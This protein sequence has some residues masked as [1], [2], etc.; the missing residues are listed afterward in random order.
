VS[1]GAVPSYVAI[2]LDQPAM[3]PEWKSWLTYALALRGV[4]LGTDGTIMEGDTLIG[5]F[6]FLEPDE[7][8]A[9]L[10][11]ANVEVRARECPWA[12]P[13]RGALGWESAGSV[14]ELLRSFL[15]LLIRLARG[16]LVRTEDGAHYE[17]LRRMAFSL[18]NLTGKFG[19]EDGEALL[20]DSSDYLEYAR[21]EAQ[22][23]LARAGFEAHVSVV[24]TTH[25]PLRIWGPMTRNGKEVPETVLRDLSMTLWAYDWSCLRDATFW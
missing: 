7:C 17:P 6:R 15:P 22:A 19:F 18:S 13:I 1:N 10:R 5:F 2:I 3:G 16:P 21:H 25:N 11:A 20:S 14:E 4:L 9:V 23:A 12:G 8:E 24:E